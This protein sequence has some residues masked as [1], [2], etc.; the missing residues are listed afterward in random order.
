MV[1]RD[2]RIA[3]NSQMNTP[4][5]EIEVLSIT[6]ICAPSLSR[7]LSLQL[8]PFVAFLAFIGIIGLAGVASVA[9]LVV[10]IPTIARAIRG[11]P[12]PE[13]VYLSLGRRRLLALAVA[14]GCG[15]PLMEGVGMIAGNALVSGIGFAL[16]LVGLVL[17][18]LV[19]RG[20]HTGHCRRIDFTCRLATS[21]S[22]HSS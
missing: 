3:I 14:L 5:M 20:S 8:D 22:S 6:D 18:L 2:R 13:E 1:D 9:G 7:A 17:L 16:L 21:I 10:V 12:K 19:Y 11:T 4:Q 15:G